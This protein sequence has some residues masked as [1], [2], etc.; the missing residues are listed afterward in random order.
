MAKTK[1]KRSKVYRGSDAKRTQPTVIHIEAV[2]R[3][4]VGQWW[5]DNKKYARPILIAL[6]IAFVVTWIIVE[7][8]RLVF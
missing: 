2:Q 5:F 8:L 6:A 1:K 7:L 4:R 3:S